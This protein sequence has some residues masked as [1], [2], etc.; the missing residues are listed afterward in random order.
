MDGIRRRRP[1][2]IV[3]AQQRLVVVTGMACVE[4]LVESAGM[5]PEK[6]IAERTTVVHRRS[7]LHWAAR[8]G[9]GDVVEYLLSR[10]SPARFQSMAGSDIR[11]A[12]GAAK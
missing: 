11:L 8:N 10:V 2:W 5:D 4:F 9:H 3:L 1:R 6:A 7:A 12:R